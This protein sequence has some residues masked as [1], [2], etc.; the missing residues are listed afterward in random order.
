MESKIKLKIQAIVI[1]KFKQLQKV[2]AD[3][4]DRISEEMMSDKI[5]LKIV[6]LEAQHIAFITQ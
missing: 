6:Y 3:I 4:I 2:L 1:L 5:Y